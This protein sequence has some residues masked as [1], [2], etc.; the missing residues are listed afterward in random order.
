MFCGEFSPSFLGGIYKQ[1]LATVVCELME[2]RDKSKQV[3]WYTFGQSVAVRCSTAGV[4]REVSIAGMQYQYCIIF[5]LSWIS[6][7][8]G[9][10]HHHQ[11]VR[12]TYRP[13]VCGQ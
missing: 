11:T 6:Y 8:H 10:Q 2:E 4:I 5:I 3:I 13:T 12:I 9:L 7:T 1:I